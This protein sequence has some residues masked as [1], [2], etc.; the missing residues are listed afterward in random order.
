MLIGID[1]GGPFAAAPG[2]RGFESSAIAAA[3]APSTAWADIADWT[4]ERLPVWKRERVD[5]L[6]AAALDWP[7]RLEVCA[8]LGAR[9]DVHARV[10]VTSDLLLRSPAAAEAHRERQLHRA[11]KALA[12]ATTQ[13]GRARGERACRLLAGERVG[14]SRLS[15]R[16]YLLAAMIPMAVVGAAQQAI[17]FFAEDEWRPEMEAFELVVDEETPAAVR[18]VLASLLPT[19]GGD[20]RFE[21]VFPDHWRQPPPHPML[22]YATHAEGDGMAPQKMLGS[23]RRWARSADEPAIQVADV[24]AWIVS[25]AITTPETPAARECFDLLRPVLVG[26]GGR[27]FDLFAIGGVRPEDAVLYEHLHS[28]APPEWLV[29]ELPS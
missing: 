18:Y 11:Q 20:D 13:D 6:H 7:E 25:R 5:E 1:A 16:D 12:I 2:D 23:A 9:G 22:G 19:I 21:F 24:A 14:Q 27:C 10:I 26:A 4:R 28:D 17:C 15:T 8:M 3:V 29:R